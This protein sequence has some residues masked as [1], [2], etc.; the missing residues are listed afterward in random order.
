MPL[1]SFGCCEMPKSNIGICAFLSS[2]KS[3]AAAH[4]QT[5]TFLSL[6]V[7]QVAHDDDGGVAL[8]SKIVFEAEAG[9]SYYIVVE[10]YVASNCGSTSVVLSESV[11]SPPP[12]PTLSLSEGKAVE[13]L[14]VKC[15]RPRK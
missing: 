13:M 5:T 15:Y 4:A 11:A 8:G 14:H 12:S 3:E 1:N 9:L 10:P 6:C 2:G 7:S